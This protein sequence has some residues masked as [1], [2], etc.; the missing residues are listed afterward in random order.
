M[1]AI[2]TNTLLGEVQ[3]Y[4]CFGGSVAQLLKLALLRRRLLA[5]VPTADVSAGA[6]ID[7]AK[8][9][10][11]YGASIMDL[12][13]LA[14]LDQIAA[15]PS[16]T[17]PSGINFQGMS[18]ATQNTGGTAV[19]A[20]GSYTPTANALLLAFIANGQSFGPPVS[21]VVGNGLTWVFIARAQGGG[22]TG[23]CNIEVWRAMGSAPTVGAVTATFAGN[24]ASAIIRIVQLTGVDTS[25]TNGSGAIVQSVTSNSAGAANPAVTLAAISGGGKNTVIGVNDTSGATGSQPEAGWLLDTNTSASA[26]GNMV[27]VYQ[28]L[29]T[30]NTIVI[31]NPTVAGYGMIGLEIKSA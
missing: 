22:G 8:C 20:S 2:P 23:P 29:S 24:V 14:L 27:A 28:K 3:C 1:A 15:A 31:T 13:E 9:F 5:L 7:Y 16:S 18:L 10:G 6:L 11:C 21:T 4:A 26:N 30:D 17:V 19:I 12:L 25:G